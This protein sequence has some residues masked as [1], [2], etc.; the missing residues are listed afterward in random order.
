MVF[1][2]LD[3]K[4]AKDNDSDVQKYQLVVAYRKLKEKTINVWYQIP[5]ITDIHVTLGRSQYCSTSHLASFHFSKSHVGSPIG[6]PG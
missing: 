3:G 2:Y 4:Q 5:N 1:T 6:Y